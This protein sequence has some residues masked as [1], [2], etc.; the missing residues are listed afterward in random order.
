[1]RLLENT[2]K[3]EIPKTRADKEMIFSRQVKHFVSLQEQF[4]FFKNSLFF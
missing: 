1:M 4:M 2:I 3:V